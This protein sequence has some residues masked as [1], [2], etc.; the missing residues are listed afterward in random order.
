MRDSGDNTKE[1]EY[2]ALAACAVSV[3]HPKE[4]S[5][6]VSRK[7]FIDLG[8]TAHIVDGVLI[9]TEKAVPLGARI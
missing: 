4:R 6:T 3:E 1:K 8:V 7:T 9:V 5:F 2:K